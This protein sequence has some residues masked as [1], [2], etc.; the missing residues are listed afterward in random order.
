MA[1]LSIIRN[2]SLLGQMEE[3]FVLQLLRGG[4]LLPTDQ[5]W[6]EGMETWEPLSTLPPSSKLGSLSP[7]LPPKVSSASSSES[8]MVQPFE[9]PTPK[10]QAFLDYLKITYSPN[11][12]SLEAIKHISDSIAAP[13]QSERLDKWFVE[14]FELYPE[15]YP[16]LGQ[17]ADLVM[18]KKTN[19]HEIS[20]ALQALTELQNALPHPQADKVVLKNKIRNQ[21][22]LLRQL[23]LGFG[24]H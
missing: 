17:T 2:G 6:Q 22:G 15:L 3:S 20:S 21:Q 16:S 10:E 5:Y 8:T 14:K 4:G 19:D 9:P 24:A 23:Y 7:T 13:S 1:L 12:S 18:L 11:I